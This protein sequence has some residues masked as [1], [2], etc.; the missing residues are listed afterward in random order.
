MITTGLLLGIT[1]TFLFT[2]IGLPRW[3]QAATTRGFVG[4]DLNKHR[5]PEVPEAGGLP[6]LLSTL[7]GFLIY[8]AYLVFMHHAPETQLITGL[9]AIATLLIAGII[10]LIDDLVGW[11]KGLGIGE[12]SSSPFSS[13]FHSQSSTR[14]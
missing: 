3:I 8:I 9:A 14:A 4:K 11:R 6:V 5:K 12:K 7:I 2:R 1:L 10:G 13:P